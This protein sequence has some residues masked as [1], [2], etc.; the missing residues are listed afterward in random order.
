M[1]KNLGLTLPTIISPLAYVSRFANIGEGSIILP[2]SIIDVEAIIGK[3][4]IINHATT[5]GH[6][7]IIEDHCHV[8][9]NC[10]LGKCKI[11]LERL[12]AL[13]AGSIMVF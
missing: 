9:A 11:K 8:S 10:V 7:A 4:S 13:I 1:L 2:F 5:I 6:G 3:N 12:L